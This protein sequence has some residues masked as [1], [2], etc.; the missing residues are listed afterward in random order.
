[1]TYIDRPRSNAQDPTPEKISGPTKTR[2]KTPDRFNRH[3]WRDAVFADPKT[4]ANAKVLAH[5]IAK[6]V[7]SETGEAYPSTLTLAKVCGFSEK[8]VRNLIPVLQSTGWIEV[9]FG[10]KGRGEKHC[11]RYSINPEKRTPCTVLADRKKRTV[12]P[13]FSRLKPDPAS[14]EPLNHKEEE[15]RFK[16]RKRAG[17]QAAPQAAL[18]ESQSLPSNGNKSVN[19]AALNLALQTDIPDTTSAP[20]GR[21]CSDRCEEKDRAET[22]ALAAA[23]YPIGFAVTNGANGTPVDRNGEAATPELPGKAREAVRNVGMG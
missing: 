21:L 7:N 10:S 3:A 6:F 4:P 22:L 13:D 8:T 12:K 2:R 11:N 18:V 14:E 15:V 1:M 5:G 19:D 16:N 9:Q 17:P 23:F 20:D